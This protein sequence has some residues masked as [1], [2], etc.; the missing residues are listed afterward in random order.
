ML[1]Y[2]D[3]SIQYIEEIYSIPIQIQRNFWWHKTTLIS[4]KILENRFTFQCR[5]PQEIVKWLLGRK[6]CVINHHSCVPKIKYTMLKGEFCYLKKLKILIL[7]RT[8]YCNWYLC[9]SVC[10]RKKFEFRASSSGV[11]FIPNFMK[12]SSAVF[13]LLYGRTYSS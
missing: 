10:T 2:I 6:K 8:C 12:I 1:V 7:S 3:K 4:S 9:T 5:K 13:E 11:M